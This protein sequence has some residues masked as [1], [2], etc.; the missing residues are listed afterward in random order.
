MTLAIV[1]A[2]VAGLGAVVRYVVD[3]AIQ[4]RHRS[5]FPLGTMTI[6]VVGSFVLGLVTGLALHH[7][8]DSR[9]A[10]IVGVGFC[11]GF[12]TFSTWAWETVALARA[13]A[14]TWAAVNVVGSV[15]LCMAAAALGLGIAAA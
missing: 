1:V 13:R 15:V 6:N 8:L 12:T 7:G 9:T 11:G 14:M 2:L 5:R 10:T 4:R 3:T